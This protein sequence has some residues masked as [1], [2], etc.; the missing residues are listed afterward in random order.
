MQDVPKTDI[1]GSELIQLLRQNGFAIDESQNNAT[2]NGNWRALTYVVDA[3]SLYPND[4]KA[5]VVVLNIDNESLSRI[6]QLSSDTLVPAGVWTRL[7]NE[8]S[9]PHWCFKTT[10]RYRNNNSRWSKSRQY[11]QPGGSHTEWHLR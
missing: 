4:R 10:H 6:Y 7:F 5:Y 9:N 2:P 8:K 1:F 11:Q 3:L